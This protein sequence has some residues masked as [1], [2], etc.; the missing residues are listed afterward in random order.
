MSKKGLIYIPKFVK[1]KE[2][3]AILAYLRT[4]HPIWE[5]RFS[6]NNPPPEGTP[7]RQLLRPVYWLGNWQFA[8]L[9]Y[10]HPPKGLYNRCVEAEAFPP[11]LA[12]MVSQIE[13]MVHQEFLE[14]D[15]PHGWHLNT[16]L[17]NYYGSRL[18]GDQKTDV[19]R[20][21]EHRD[22]EPGPVAS[23]SLGERAL[24][25]FVSSKSKQHQSQVVLQQWLEDS[26]LQI[27]GSDR[28]KKQLFHRVQRVE[29]KLSPIDGLHTSNFETRRINFTFRYVPNDHIV[30]FSRL[31]KAQQED[32]EP[33]VRELATHS[34]FFTE[35]LEAK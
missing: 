33:Y 3:E 9:D 27:F 13:S 14:K 21:G 26:S 18:E 15:V 8:C 17:I 20:V 10:Y 6:K 7:N 23:V 16:C 28:F 35:A 22:Y 32:I 30:E 1:A 11:V 31:P 34:A 5:M 4:L 12:E 25:Q 24:F 2:K 19:A 29:K